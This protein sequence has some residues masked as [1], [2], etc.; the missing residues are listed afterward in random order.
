MALPAL[1]P[2]L[3]VAAAGRL[4]LYVP[5][6]SYYYFEIARNLG[7][8]STFDGVGQTN[9]Y[10]PLWLLVITPIWWVFDGGDAPVHLAKRR[11]A[12]GRGE[13]AAHWPPRNRLGGRVVGVI[14][15]ALFAVIPAP[16]CS[17]WMS[18]RRASRCS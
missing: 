3:W 11:R 18:R 16:C 5:D 8:R 7:V 4:V 14:A 2:R 9:G 10:H 13:H 17:A 15:T 6:D 12:P 1:V